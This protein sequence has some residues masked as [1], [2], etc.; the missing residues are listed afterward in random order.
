M[1]SILVLG[2]RPASRNHKCPAKTKGKENKNMGHLV[3]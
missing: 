3:T 1:D 2:G